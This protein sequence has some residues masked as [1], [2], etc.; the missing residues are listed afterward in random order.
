LVSY[1]LLLGLI[2]AFSAGIS[3]LGLALATWVSRLGRA[4]ALC[5]LAYAGFSIGWI[6]FVVVVSRPSRVGWTMMTGSPFYGTYLSTLAVA[7]Q[8]STLP[9]EYPGMISPFLWILIH[10]G[11]AALLFAATLATFDRCL[12]RVSKTARQPIPSS[13]KK[14]VAK[15]DPDFGSGFPESRQYEGGRRK[16]AQVCVDP[17]AKV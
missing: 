3:S 16:H 15:L 12:G 14:S 1:V 5:V 9:A 7:P 17:P 6:A 10:G 8:G 4:V 2:L 13:G 11:I